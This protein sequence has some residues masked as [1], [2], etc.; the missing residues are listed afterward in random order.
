[1]RILFAILLVVTVLPAY[2]S[3]IM[4][5]PSVTVLPSAPASVEIGQLLSDTTINGFLEQEGVVLG[6]SVNVGIT[7]PGTWVCCSG[8]PTGTIA[9]GEEVNSYLLRAA[10]DAVTQG[11]H[12]FQ[13]SIT[14]GNGEKIVGV[15]V[16]YGNISNTNGIFAAP[17]T[18]YPPSSCGQCGQEPANAPPIGDSVTISSNMQT[19]Y[20]N[21]RVADGNM[22]AIRIL[23]TVPEPAEFILLGSGLVALGFIKRRQF[24]RRSS[25]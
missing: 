2:G 13:G 6:S 16:G 9:A 19:I 18:L 11:L 12:D 4:F 8:L 20:V 21:F 17:G 1:M 23:T 25:R 10:P 14:F 15:I 5:S 7:S 22:D 3:I 24:F